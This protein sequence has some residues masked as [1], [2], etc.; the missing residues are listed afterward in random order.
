VKWLKI[1]RG[2][3][4]TLNNVLD[5]NHQIP[6]DKRIMINTQQSSL[7]PASLSP[8]K[9]A[10]I[11]SGCGYLDGSEITETVSALICLAELKAEVVF[12]APETS[13]SQE[14]ALLESTMPQS[15]TLQSSVS[16]YSTLESSILQSSTF[17][18]EESSRI[19]RKQVLPL[20][21]LDSKNFDGLVLP[22]GYG[23]AK[24]LSNWAERGPCCEV[25]DSVRRVI[26]S[27]YEESKPLC[28][29]CIAPAIVAQVLGSKKITVTL[30]LDPAVA[31]FA[32]P[33]G[34][35]FELCPSE[36]FITDRLHKIISTPAYMNETATAFDVFTGIKKALCEFIEMA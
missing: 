29:F 27:F 31:R 14:K 33:T 1:L 32:Q 8:K 35:Y 12:F 5:K 17:F 34:A 21:E 19:T 10:L 11:L 7:S 6:Y 9:V 3:L 4:K 26:T 24:H 15:S 22:G 30:G 36:D 13:V 23:V 20:R 25:L 28:A 16:G 18:M 2:G